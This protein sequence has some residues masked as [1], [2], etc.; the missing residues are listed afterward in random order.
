MSREKGMLR[1]CDICGA[2]AFAKAAGEGETDGGYTRWNKFEA[3][4]EGWSSDIKID[5][6][7]YIDTCPKCTAKHKELY[8]KL[9]SE[10]TGK[11]AN[12]NEKDSDAI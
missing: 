9:I 10:L 1:T 3:F 4:P 2:T 11:E 7:G 8:E 6:K 12:N 5:G